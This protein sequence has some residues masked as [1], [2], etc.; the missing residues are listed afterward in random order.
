MKL[1][2]GPLSMFGAKVQVALIEK[3]IDAEIEHVPFNL[4]NFYN[5]RHA[6][7]LR[8]NPKQQVPVLIDDGLELFDS[9]VIF[10]YLED[11]MPEPSLWPDTVSE[12]ALARRL[13]LEADEILF[14]WVQRVMPHRRGD[15]T[16]EGVANGLG[17]LAQHFTRMNAQ[18]GDQ[19]VLACQ[20][21]YADIAL[22]GV[23]FFARF[24]GVGP[25]SEL[26]SLKAWEEAAASRNS[27][28][29]VFGAMTEYLSRAMQGSN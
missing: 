20:F 18:I 11:K 10:E 27:I 28:K 26:Y 9:T 29:T 5:P 7:V 4:T 12:R 1:L 23:V 6:E 15:F 25:S 24:L 21:S 16:D 8:I 17:D 19:R 2:T 14:E 13:E 3:D 22:Y